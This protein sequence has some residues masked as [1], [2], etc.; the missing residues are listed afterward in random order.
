MGFQ[1]S[2]NAQPAPA[3]QGDFASQNPRA[4]VLAG[5]GQLVSPVGGLTVGHFAFV[6]AATGLVS[7]SY[8]AAGGA[9]CQIGFLGR[10]SQALIT[11]FLGQNTLVVPVGFMVTLYDAGEFWARFGG[12][13]TEGNTV[14]ADETTGRPVSGSATD[15]VTAA[16]GATGTL[17][18]NV[19]AGTANQVTVNTLSAGNVYVGDIVVSTNVPV[20]TTITGQISGT[21]NGT[22][23]YSISA[24]A[25]A[26][27]G[28]TAF[29][30]TS[31]TLNVTAVLTGQINVGD[32]LS[33]TG[34]TAGTTVTAVGTGSGGVGT[35]VVSVGQNFASTTVTV[36]NGNV[37]TNFK[38]RSNCLPGELAM[39]ST[40]GA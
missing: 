19:T 14:Y 21:A 13:A 31:T 35:Y 33:G 2:V 30:T 23:L 36:V 27:A 20:G 34:V 15:T 3:V 6:A 4:S 17:T 39:I 16:V 22:G 37:A 1:T 29:T 8:L 24:N 5:A 12:G 7:Q 11:T 9:G 32:V 18:T 26:A 38:V 40:W 10:E 28:P 25:S